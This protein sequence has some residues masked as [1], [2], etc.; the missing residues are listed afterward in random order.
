MK[1][2]DSVIK[3]KLAYVVF[4]GGR[5]HWWTRFLKKGFYHCFVILG[6]GY[7]WII[8][9]PVMDFT[10]VVLVQDWCIVDFLKEKGYKFILTKPKHI[11]GKRKNA[12]RLF[13]CVEVAKS[14][15]GIT[16]HFIFTPYQLF[17]YIR[18]EKEK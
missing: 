11:Y 9:D 4:G 14:L 17:K 15:L 12:L 18:R 1:M 2:F 10:D 8:I 6:D 16:E 7:K 3:P 13:T 5:T